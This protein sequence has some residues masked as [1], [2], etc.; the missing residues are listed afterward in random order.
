MTETP[1]SSPTWRN[2]RSGA[3]PILILLA[4]VLGVSIWFAGS[5]IAKLF[6]DDCVSVTTQIEGGSRTTR[7]CS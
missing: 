4:M 1:N 6:S 5:S 7:T 3:L 2:S